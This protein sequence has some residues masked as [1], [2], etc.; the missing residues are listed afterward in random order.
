[1]ARVG[2]RW[3]VCRLVSSPTITKGVHS[4]ARSA[5]AR[6]AHPI[7][8][9]EQARWRLH[10][11]SPSPGPP[12]G[13]SPRP[14]PGHSHRPRPRPP[15][16]Q[17]P[18]PPPR[19]PPLLPLHRQAHHRFLG[20][21][22]PPAPP[23]QTAPRR[24]RTGSTCPYHP[25]PVT[26]RAHSARRSTSHWTRCS[27]SRTWCPRRTH[28]LRRHR[29]SPATPHSAART[30]PTKQQLLP[31]PPR[32]Q[33]AR[34]GLRASR[35]RCR[36]AQR[37]AACPWPQSAPRTVQHVV[38]PPPR[39]PA[40]A[41]ARE[42]PELARLV[43]CA[44]LSW[45]DRAVASPQRPSP[46]AGAASPPPRRVRVHPAAPRPASAGRPSASRGAS[47]AFSPSLP[48]RPPRPPRRA[49]RHV[50]HCPRPCPSTRS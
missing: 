13:H 43:L 19:P 38:S 26:S 24:H 47:A 36:S 4:L 21:H 29:A 15:L 49:R 23:V 50:F 40:V 18:R 10:L 41:A 3:V 1:M 8:H 30:L 11:L 14:P 35:R 33:Q 16:R 6:D 22:S 31:P 5:N 17:P 45:S 32:R 37:A 44:R 27:S 9:S 28:Q 20:C 34:R 7:I 2:G 39:Q 25:R 46:W 42:R 48:T 12:P